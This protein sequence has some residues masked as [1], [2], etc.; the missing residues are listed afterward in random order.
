MKPDSRLASPTVFSWATPWRRLARRVNNR[1]S[2]RAGA[3]EARRGPLT[4]ARQRGSPLTR[5]G[6]GKRERRH[7]HEAG[8]LSGRLVC[9]RAVGGRGGAGRR[10]SSSPTQCRPST[11][12]RPGSTTSQPSGS[13]RRPGQRNGRRRRPRRRRSAA[14]S[15]SPRGRRPDAI[16]VWRRAAGVGLGA[17]HLLRRS[18]WQRRRRQQPWRQRPRLSQRR[19]GRPSARR[20]RRRRRAPEAAALAATEDQFQL[21]AGP[22]RA[23]A[24][25][26]AASRSPAPTGSPSATAARRRAPRAAS[27]AAAAAA[28]TAAAAAAGP[29]SGPK[30]AAAAAARSWTAL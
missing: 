7:E 1:S 20:R 17:V 10:P 2:R 8:T 28:A 19:R 12:P 16:L 15:C 9:W 18:R 3:C 25:T 13:R 21:G 6:H 14:T 27:K 23:A 30:P 5:I 24:A 29:S 22:L 11:S 4:R 26:T